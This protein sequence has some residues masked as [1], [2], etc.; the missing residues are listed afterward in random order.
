[1]K[2]FLAFAI[3]ACSLLL[4]SCSDRPVAPQQ[5]SSYLNATYPGKYVVKL[6][7]RHM[8]YEVR[9]S[10]GMEIEFNRNFQPIDVDYDD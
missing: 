6:E 5:I 4:S 2:K 7:R 3:L 1:M 8:G 9:I 10:N